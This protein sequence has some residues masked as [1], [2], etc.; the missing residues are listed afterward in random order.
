[1]QLSLIDWGLG[2]W[3]GL[4]SLQLCARNICLEKVVWRQKSFPVKKTYG[5]FYVKRQAHIKG[6]VLGDVLITQVI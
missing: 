1:M 3:G 6:H 2:G 5:T 4:I